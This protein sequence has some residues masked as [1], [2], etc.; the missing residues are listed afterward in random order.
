[1]N[2]K[3]EIA[4]SQIPEKMDEFVR[5]D[6]GLAALTGLLD[7]GAIR[8]SATN[9]ACVR[10]LRSALNDRWALIEYHQKEVEGK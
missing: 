5:A 1:M 7:T 2:C 4:V 9:E 10:A 8:V 3:F 6:D